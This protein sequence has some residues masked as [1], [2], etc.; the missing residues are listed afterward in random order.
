M[1]GA[2]MNR[3]IDFWEFNFSEKSHAARET[4]AKKLD[5]VLHIKLIME[6]F[7]IG[8]KSIFHIST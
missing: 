6:T 3:W 4:Q 5:E 2:E 7:R 8:L 1:V